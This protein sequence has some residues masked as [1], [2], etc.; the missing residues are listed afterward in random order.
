MPHISGISRGWQLGGAITEGKVQRPDQIFR[1]R[2]MP[3]RVWKNLPEKRNGV[4]KNDGRSYCLHGE[5]KEVTRGI[6]ESVRWR[7][8]ALLVSKIITFTLVED[9]LKRRMM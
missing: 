3:A 9:A 5:E 2:Y 7:P 6:A 1:S 8:E 4:P